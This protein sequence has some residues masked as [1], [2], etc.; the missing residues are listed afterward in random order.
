M[1]LLGILRVL[2]YQLILNEFDRLERE[3]RP[4]K[5]VVALFQY[6]GSHGV[7]RTAAW[8]SNEA[9]TGWQPRADDGRVWLLDKD[10]LKVW[11]RNLL[12]LRWLVENYGRIAELP[13][14]VQQALEETIGRTRPQ[15]DQSILVPRAGGVRLLVAGLDGQ[16]RHS[17]LSIH[18]AVLDDF[19]VLWT[20]AYASFLFP[21]AIGLPGYCAGCGKVL[22]TETK[23]KASAQA[24]C[25][26]CRKADWIA[27]NK[28][29][30]VAGRK[31]E[32]S[33]RAKA[34]KRK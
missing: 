10:G 21:G 16:P 23:Q 17:S 19:Q 29:K 22:T 20:C 5:A 7:I 4:A 30:A 2:L 25:G 24:L 32:Q 34:K 11:Q 31:K 15:I 26:R 14:E 33:D 12:A 27:K 6:L 28:A 3:A 18:Y 8:E 1:F 9:G 13:S